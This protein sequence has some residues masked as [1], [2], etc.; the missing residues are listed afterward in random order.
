MKISSCLLG[1]KEYVSFSEKKNEN[2][3]SRTCK[4]FQRY[5]I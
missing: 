2:I 4:I 5:Y 1:E 3:S